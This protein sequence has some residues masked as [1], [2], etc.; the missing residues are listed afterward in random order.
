MSALAAEI[1]RV[2]AEPA[3]YLACL[4]VVALGATV[5]TV[6]GQA[7]GMMVAPLLTLAAPDRVPGAVL[8]LGVAVTALSAGRDLSA[9]RWRELGPALGGRAAGS[10]LASL[11]LLAL[12]GRAAIAV[13]I[14]LATL[15]AVAL[16]VAGL[17]VAITRRSLLAAGTLSGFMAA[18]TSI[19]APPMGLLYQRER[20]EAV[21]A[22]LNLFF[23]IGMAFSLAALAPHGLLTGRD[24]AFALSLTPALALGFL[25]GRAAAGRLAGRSLRPAILTLATGAAVLILA[26]AAFR[27]AP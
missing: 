15:L 10:A 18:F 12:P 26:R 19:G 8:I 14:G 23:L 7:F 1:A 9:V 24:L 25:I 2:L 20:G 13:A 11:A 6:T 4:G 27:A 16:S 5:Q 22:T 3:T 17:R 21:R